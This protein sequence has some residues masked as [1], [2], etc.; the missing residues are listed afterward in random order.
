[1]V[2]HLKKRQGVDNI[3]QKQ[4]DSDYAD[5]LALLANTPAQAGSLLY[6]IEQT[7]ESISF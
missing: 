4:S 6:R 3:S 7:A 5:N 1:M 2:S